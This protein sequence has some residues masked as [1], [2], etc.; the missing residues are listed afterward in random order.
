MVRQYTQQVKDQLRTFKELTSAFLRRRNK[1]VGR[2]KT[3]FVLTRS[4]FLGC[5]KCSLSFLLRDCLHLLRRLF[6]LC[7]F[8]LSS[9]TQVLQ[10]MTCCNRSASAP[11]CPNGRRR[12]T[13][14]PAVM[15]GTFR[16]SR[17]NFAR[18]PPAPVGAGGTTNRRQRDG[19]S[20]F[21]FC[22]LQEKV[23]VI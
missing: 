18:W 21:L 11:S 15:N 2:K 7:T 17:R 13:E 20:N 16:T 6:L 22:C 23:D 10:P 3:P 14:M 5:S 12:R 8:L 9:T 1:K 4:P 19:D